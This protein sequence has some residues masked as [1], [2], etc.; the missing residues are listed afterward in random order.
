MHPVV[1]SWGFTI[2]RLRTEAGLSQRELAR[3]VGVDPSHISYVEKGKREPSLSLL[4]TICDEMGHALVLGKRA[5]SA[6][7]KGK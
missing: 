2:R 1:A 5:Q 3:R 7:E 6:Q 4:L